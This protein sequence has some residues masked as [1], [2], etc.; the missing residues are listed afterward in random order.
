MARHSEAVSAFSALGHGHRLA[1]Y[2]LLVE[3][4]PNGLS[5]GA[6]AGRLGIPPSSLTFHTQALVRAGLVRQRRE[7][8][9]LLYTADF[10]AMNVLVAYLT[11]NCCGGQPQT[12]APACAPDDAASTQAENRRRSA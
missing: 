4:G 10:A 1:V 9:L 7:S 3:A 8:R 5:A 12:C 6:I 11:E 2:R